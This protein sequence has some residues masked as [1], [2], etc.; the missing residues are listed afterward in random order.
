MHNN[1]VDNNKALDALIKS[2]SG[3]EEAEGEIT[4]EE[5]GKVVYTLNLGDTVTTCEG[6]ATF[7]KDDEYFGLHHFDVSLGPANSMRLIE[8]LLALPE[9]PD[10]EEP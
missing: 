5:R 2:K 8:F 7:I 4:S 6:G 9:E 10:E 3:D 1:V